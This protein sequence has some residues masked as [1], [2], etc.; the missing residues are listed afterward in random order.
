LVAY[1]RRRP[2][3]ATVAITL[4]PDSTGTVIALSLLVA[5]WAVIAL[6]IVYSALVAV[7]L[8]VPMI[9]G[10]D[11][12]AARE[13]L[14]LALKVLLH[15]V[16]WVLILMA[17]F[18]SEWDASILDQSFANTAMK[19]LATWPAAV[20]SAL[21]TVLVTLCL[22]PF[23]KRRPAWVRIGNVFL[24]VVLT[25][26]AIGLFFLLS[27]KVRQQGGSF[28]ELI[29]LLGYGPLMLVSMLFLAAAIG[30]GFCSGQ[31]HPRAG[32]I[33]TVLFAAALVAT[34][35]FLERFGPVPIPLAGAEPVTAEIAEAELGLWGAASLLITGLVGTL[36]PAEGIE[37]A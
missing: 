29:Y 5:C 13:Q 9:D 17:L 11:G 4:D 24:C 36:F 19:A 12:L 18:R 16:G 31:T 1:P 3:D 35:V 6:A 15:L 26:M 23:R 22:P 34:A 20:A 37:H 10:L 7:R 14:L 21:L 2:I 25:G 33:R 28:P 32:G 30:V 27:T 8:F